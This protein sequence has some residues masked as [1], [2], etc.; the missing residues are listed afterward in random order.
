MKQICL[1]QNKSHDSEG[2]AQI[3]SNE[4]FITRMP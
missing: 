3:V 1:F 2:L 4:F